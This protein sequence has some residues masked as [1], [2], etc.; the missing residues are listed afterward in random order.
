VRTGRKEHDDVYPNYLVTDSLSILSVSQF[1]KLLVYE[2]S[3]LLIIRGFE[4]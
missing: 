1:R 3:L 2:T 4:D